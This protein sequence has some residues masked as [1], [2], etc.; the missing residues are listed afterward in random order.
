MSCQCIECVG[1][2]KEP[3]DAEIIAALEAENAELRRD[4]ERYRS[5]RR[6]EFD[7][8]HKGTVAPCEAWPRIEREFNTQYDAAIDAALAKIKETT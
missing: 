7:A 1:Y 8:Q 5:K 4:A 3:T 6:A 2:Q